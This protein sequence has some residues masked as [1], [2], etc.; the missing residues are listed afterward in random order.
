[1]AAVTTEALFAHP[2]AFG[3]GIAAACAE[4]SPVQRAICR[5]ADGLPLGELARDEGVIRSFG[6]EDAIA[7]LPH[8]PPKELFCVCCIASLE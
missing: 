7:A 1:M 4:P 2:L 6:G 5:V 3:S 8:E